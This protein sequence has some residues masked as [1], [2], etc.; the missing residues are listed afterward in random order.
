MVKIIKGGQ[1]NAA[2]R[3]TWSADTGQTKSEPI[4]VQS[5]VAIVKKLNLQQTEK[6]KNA[7]GTTTYLYA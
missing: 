1:S 2:Y 6:T 5:A 7:D 4:E 3:L